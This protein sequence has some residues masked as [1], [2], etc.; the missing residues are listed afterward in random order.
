MTIELVRFKE[1]KN[2][3]RKV[4]PSLCDS[5]SSSSILIHILL[6]TRPTCRIR[7]TKWQS[8][9]NCFQE[10]INIHIRTENISSHE[11]GE[12]NLLLKD[13]IYFV[14]YV[15]DA[16]ITIMK[17]YVSE[18]LHVR[19]CWMKNVWKKVPKNAEYDLWINGNNDNILNTKR[20]TS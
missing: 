13:I 18:N 9:K 12:K 19:L 20:T 17:I 10:W 11:I 6:F 14:Y 5:H 2:V 15:V 8:D 16:K 4:M 7:C 3:W 1:T